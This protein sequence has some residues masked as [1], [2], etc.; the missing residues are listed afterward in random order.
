MRADADSPGTPGP[1]DEA[2]GPIGPPR[3]AA[4]PGE[5]PDTD[6]PGTLP[7]ESTAPHPDQP[8]EPGQPTDHGHSQP[9]PPVDP[10]EPG[11][12]LVQLAAAGFPVAGM[13]DE[14]RAVLAA[15]TGEELHVLLDVKRRLDGA[16]PEVL[17]HEA[18]VVGGLFF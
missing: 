18:S 16:E 4:A 1:Y 6:Q 15:L 9:A 17:A 12:A 10:A 3:A 5:P 2:R 13:D 11:P 7:A 8:P 14:Q